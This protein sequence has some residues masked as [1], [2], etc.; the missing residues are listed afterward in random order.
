MSLHKNIELYVGRK[1]GID[2]Y[3]FR[4]N[5]ELLCFWEWNIADKPQP[6][7]AE[8]EALQPLLEVIELK[9]L[10]MTPREFVLGLINLGVTRLQIETLINANDIAWAELSYATCIV[11]GNPL[12]DLL[13][14]QLGVTTEQLDN[15]FLSKKD[16]SEY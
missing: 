6:T 5:E 10:K 7:I 3:S 11:R 13:C 8:L 14:G 12:L 4:E 15:L 1:V 2:E 9:K 16:L